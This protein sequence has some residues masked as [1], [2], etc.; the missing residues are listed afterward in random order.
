MNDSVCLADYCEI[1]RC[2]V[3]SGMAMPTFWDVA[4]CMEED[5]K[6]LTVDCVVC[7]Q[8][9]IYNVQQGFFTGVKRLQI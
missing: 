8:Y 6:D 2:D 4:L 7:H 3:L 1:F 5:M 9:I